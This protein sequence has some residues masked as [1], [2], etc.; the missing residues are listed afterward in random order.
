V[1]DPVTILLIRH[2]TNPS[3]GKGL[4]GWLPGVSLDATGRQQAER[5]ADWLDCVPLRAIYSSPLERAMETGEP[6]ARRK[7]LEIVPKTDLGEIHFGAWQGKSF[8]EIERDESWNR[9]NCY[10]SSTR[11]PGGELMLET[12][13]R[14]VR[15]VGEIKA[16][17]GGQAVAVFSHA[18]AIKSVVMHFL[19]I[20]LDFH[21]RLEI[22]PASVTILQLFP[23]SAL[24]RAVNICGP[25]EYY[26]Y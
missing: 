21:L 22:M 20:P 13:A 1:T 23:D 26:K 4:T 14:M 5:L 18:D 2:A 9:F 8:E 10:R 11:A 6:I 15:A 16:A 25:I 12:Q 7:N 3:V 24:V 19:G 17:H